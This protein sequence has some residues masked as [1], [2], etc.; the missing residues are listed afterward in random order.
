MGGVV[1]QRYCGGRVYHWV[2]GSRG[3]VE[4]VYITGSLG[5][6]VLWRTC[7]SLGRWV[8]RYC[9][10]RV[11]HWV[12][13]SRG[14]VEDVYITGA[15]GPEVLWRTCISLGHWVKTKTIT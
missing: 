7:I 6:E 9:G 8:Q 14:T 2:A 10:G 13:G 3:T 4:D 12:T 5:P 11:Y 1:V 15:L